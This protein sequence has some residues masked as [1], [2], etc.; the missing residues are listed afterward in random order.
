MKFQRCA[1]P[2]SRIFELYLD[3]VLKNMDLDWDSRKKI[4][5]KR[6]GFRFEAKGVDSDSRCTDSHITE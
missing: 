3:S 5:E 2:D 4:H 6:G 1:N